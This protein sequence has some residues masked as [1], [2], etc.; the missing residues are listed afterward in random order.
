MLPAAALLLTAA[1]CSSGSTERP[2]PE[3]PLSG[4]ES[5][6]ACLA[7][8]Q[9]T[10]PECPEFE[11][12]QDSTGILP[13]DFEA[14]PSTNLLPDPF[15]FFDGGKVKADVSD[16]ELRRKELLSLFEDCMWGHFPPKP[17]I[18][19]VEVLEEDAG[20]GWKSRTVKLLFGPED[21]GNVR[22]KL[23]IPVGAPSP[24]GKY[25]LT[26]YWNNYSAKRSRTWQELTEVKSGRVIHPNVPTNARWMPTSNRL[27]YTVKGNTANDLIVFDPATMREEVLMENLPEGRFVWSPT[28]DYLVYTDT[29][30]GKEAEGPLKQILMPDDRIPG[31]R[32]RS[33]LVKYDLKTGVSQRLTFSGQSVYLNDIAPDGSKLLC[34]SSRPHITECPFSLTSLFEIDLAT[35]KA[36]TLVKEDPY[37][38]QASYSPDGKKLVLLGGPDALGGIGKNYAP[39][40]IGNSFDVQAFLMDLTT[41]EVKPITRDFNPSVTLLQWNRTD[42]C[43]Y[44]S[45]TDKDCQ[46]IY[47]YTPEKDTFEMLPLEEDVISSFSVA[48]D[49]PTMA[50][51]VGGGNTSTG[52]A[53]LYNARKRTSEL[54][55]NPMKERLDEINFGQMEEWSFTASD[56]TV[57]EGMMC[58]PPDFDPEKKYPLIVYYYGGTT[59][60]TR[61][62]TSPYCAQLF[63]SRD[64]VVYII[65]PS[66][67]IG[68]GQEFSARHVNAWGDY[69]ADNIIEGTK[70]FCEAHPF[71]NPERVGCLGASYGGFM[72][73]YLQTRTDIFAAAASHA[74]I[75]NVTSYWGE[76]YWGY[77]YNATAAASSYPWS[78]PELFTK[79]GA[80]FNADKIHTP[81]LLLHGTVDTNVP[82]GESIQLYN[83][84]KILGRPVAFI[85]VDGENHFISDYDKRVLWHNSIMA[86]FAKWLQDSPEWWEDLYK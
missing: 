55:A 64:Y 26:Y 70:K 82:I 13:P 7:W 9:E 20:E 38:N 4:S 41:R 52:A 85:T 12:W 30:K 54:W 74:G 59:P 1:S 76:G 43:I 21:K 2:A 46:H 50:A 18:S 32:D 61:G 68:Y 6:E 86:W 80:L 48:E 71:V 65:Q 62:M 47:R 22:V 69:T 66:G 75:S 16:W 24:D 5:G 40:A 56:G 25:L 60:T 44:F 57:I 77:S 63:A 14:L 53:Y 78:R 37:L 72:T 17:E 39:H 49:N 34:T 10:L 42:G 15:T 36:D 79:H 11:A 67:A 51:Y 3:I 23:T 73:M 33:Y 84:L 8:M 28:E 27:Y 29:D 83:A 45:T 35:M 31:W 19:R 58:L 81:L